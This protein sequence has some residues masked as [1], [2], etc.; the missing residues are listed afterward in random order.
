MSLFTALYTGVAALTAQSSSISNISR[1]IS[2]VN[3]T[4]YKRGETSFETLLSGGASGAGGSVRA[5]TR[6][7]IVSTGTFQ[8]TG[9]ATDVAINGSGFFIVA[10]DMANSTANLYTRAGS[11]D[12]DAEGYL[13]NSAGYYAKG[14]RYN[15]DGSLGG[16]IDNANSLQLIDLNIGKTTAAA[17]GKLDLTMNLNASQNA[18]AAAP[19]F[20]RNFTV[21]DSLG[22]GHELTFEFEKT[23]DNTW[24]LTVT[25]PVGG[26]SATPVNLVFDSSGRL[27]TPAAGADGRI[28][29]ALDPF[30]WGNGS[31]VASVNVDLTNVNQL[32]GAS[33][34]FSFAQDGSPLGYRTDIEVTDDGDIMARY[35]NG[36]TVPLYRL[37]VATF[38]NINA[39]SPTAGNAYTETADS[40][41]VLL[42]FPGESGSGKFMSRNLEA[43]NVDIADEFSKM[44]VAQRAYSA[45]SKVISTSDRMLD[46]LL[47]LR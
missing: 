11:F 10:P 38:A 14:L 33:Q 3:T 8:P 35:D 43:S 46:E 15:P 4:G 25:D 45:G 28:T 31:N 27:T 17:T 9:S 20:E 16:S 18:A 6:Q 5:L 39:L 22:I 2:N 37:P 47:S 24:D 19:H 21:Y 1:N 42:R 44:I 23:A 32:S 12:V 30:N 7:N 41:S 40:G 13:R 29:A 36:R 34:V 26:T